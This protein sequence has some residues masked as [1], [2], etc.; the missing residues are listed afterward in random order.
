MRL[1]TQPS[2]LF[3]YRSLRPFCCSRFIACDFD[4]S[5]SDYT[6]LPGGPCAVVFGCSVEHGLGFPTAAFEGRAVLK[7]NA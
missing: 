3:K 1:V 6:P 7:L 4:R 2:V 5:R